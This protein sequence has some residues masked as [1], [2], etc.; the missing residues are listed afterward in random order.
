[1]AN[2]LFY[3][4][5][6]YLLWQDLDLERGSLLLEDI[7]FSPQYKE[8]MEAMLQSQMELRSST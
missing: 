5:L 4:I 3:E 1:M 6:K 8:K 2:E 7:L